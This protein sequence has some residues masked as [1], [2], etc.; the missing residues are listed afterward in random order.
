MG[1]ILFAQGPVLLV[2]GLE[3]GHFPW[4]WITMV[5]SLYTGMQASAPLSTNF[6]GPGIDQQSYQVRVGPR[7]TG[8]VLLLGTFLAAVCSPHSWLPSLNDYNLEFES[9]SQSSCSSHQLGSATVLLY[10]FEN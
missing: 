5:S 9:K 6:Q 7:G 8:S 4:S 2:V 1:T 10:Q 3:C